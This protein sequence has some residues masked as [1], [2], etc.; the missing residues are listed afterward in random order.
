MVVHQWSSIEYPKKTSY[1]TTSVTEGRV[2][3][4][5]AKDSTVLKR[6][7]G[8]YRDRRG[9]KE[10]VTEEKNTTGKLDLV[11]SGDETREK[12]KEMEIH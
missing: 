9:V 5:K 1:P 11:G 4:E 8:R 7:K 12:K 2:L 6:T 3:E 10:E